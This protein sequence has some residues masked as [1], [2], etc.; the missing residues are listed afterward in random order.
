[1]KTISLNL[2]E[3]ASGKQL[4]DAFKGSLSDLAVIFEDIKKF[5][6]TKEEIESIKVDGA[7]PDVNGNIPLSDKKAE[8]TITEIELNNETIDYLKAT[9]SEMDKKKEFSLKNTAI[10]TLLEKIK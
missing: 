5:V 7:V 8:E 10:L 4:L 1:M 2:L 6:I 9:I 3:K